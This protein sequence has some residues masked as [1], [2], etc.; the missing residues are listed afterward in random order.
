MP[1]LYPTYD[2][3]ARGLFPVPPQ[4][5]ASVISVGGYS[6]EQ[7][8]D[9]WLFPE[10]SEA[11]EVRSPVGNGSALPVFLDKHQFAWFYYRAKLWSAS[12][13]G[14]YNFE[15][16]ESGRRVEYSGNFSVEA[17]LGRNL[18]A[19]GNALIGDDSFP[20]ERS[21]LYP[22][23]GATEFSLGTTFFAPPIIGVANGSATYTET[24]TQYP[25][26]DDEDQSLQVSTSQETAVLEVFAGEDNRQEPDNYC[27]Y[28]WAD[29]QT[30]SNFGEWMKED[31]VIA[32]NVMVSIG[33]K[34]ASGQSYALPPFGS[35]DAT[36][37]LC[38]A[39]INTPWE[40]Q[41]VFSIYRSDSG[42]EEVTFSSVTFTP[43]EFW[44]YQAPVEE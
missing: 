33:S 35:A 21:L 19:N 4:K 41:P 3:T 14:S 12:M 18:D 15:T 44:T 29:G 39:V 16:T 32:C 37:E 43:T 1:S 23:G 5:T 8:G 34:W 27:S 24:R 42:E 28:A 26:I 31:S 2:F 38:Q 22:R 7:F 20:H 13:S 10:E 17:I 40:P 36:K 6:I 11:N 9:Y 30:D 25:L